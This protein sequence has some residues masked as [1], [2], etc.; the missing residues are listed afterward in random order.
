[1][2]YKVKTWETLECTYEVEATSKDNAWERVLNNEGKQIHKVWKENGSYLVE[3]THP[4]D[5]PE[6]PGNVVDFKT[7]VLEIMKRKKPIDKE[8]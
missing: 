4:V 1:M 2:K 7:K 6:F 3:S 5:K 8:K